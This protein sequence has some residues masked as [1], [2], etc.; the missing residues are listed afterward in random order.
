MSPGNGERLGGED[1]S[2]QRGVAAERTDCK[3][4]A[5]VMEASRQC[6]RSQ[7]RPFFHESSMALRNCSA[8]VSDLRASN[9]EPPEPGRKHCLTIATR[10]W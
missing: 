8:V 2:S 3:R 1:C 7:A 10:A 6:E 9:S 4:H 5:R